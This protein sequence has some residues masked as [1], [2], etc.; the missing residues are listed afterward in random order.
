MS[1][2]RFEPATLLPEEKIVIDLANVDIK[3]SEKDQA[4]LLPSTLLES[5][6]SFIV[7][8]LYGRTS[9]IL[10]DFKMALNSKE[11]QKK[12]T[13]GGRIL[14]VDVVGTGRIRIEMCDGSEVTLSDVRHVPGIRKIL[15]SLGSLNALGYKYRAQD[16]I[17]KVSKMLS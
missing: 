16:E 9:I 7:T 15:I 13:D 2:T 3:I 12:T 17:M 8:V 5:Y 6:E 1:D 14:M 11:L 4:L 10:E